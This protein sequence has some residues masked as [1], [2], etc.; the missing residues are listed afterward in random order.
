MIPIS[1]AGRTGWP[2]WLYKNDNK[3][4]GSQ[5][6]NKNNVMI[7]ICE[8]RL[9][10]HEDKFEK[11]SEQCQKNC[12]YAYKAPN[13]QFMQAYYNYLT[14]QDFNLVISDLNKIAEQV[15]SK[16]HFEGEPII[17][18]LVYEAASR[19]CGERFGLIKWFKDNNYILEEW[20]PDI[21]EKESLF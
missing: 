2:Y 16:N 11:L 20:T 4:I 5:Y 14:E 13:C 10:F 8:K 12:P 19:L 17:V 9:A 6:L 3:A 21:D 7:G 18:L 1:T 15:R